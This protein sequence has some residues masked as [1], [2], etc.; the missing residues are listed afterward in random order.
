MAISRISLIIDMPADQSRY[1][2][3]ESCLQSLI[4]AAAPEEVHI[5]STLKD[6][7]CI[8]TDSQVKAFLLYLSYQYFS[9]PGAP[10]PVILHGFYKTK[11]QVIS[12]GTPSAFSKKT[13]EQVFLSIIKKQNTVHYQNPYI[14]ERAV[15]MI[16]EQYDSLSLE[17]LS[18][19]LDV[20]HSYLCRIISKD[21]GYSFLELLHFRR[22]LAV[23]GEFLLP[24]GCSTEALCLNLGY[25]SL[26]HFHR[27]FKQYTELTPAGAKK[28]L[29][30]LNAD[31]I[32]FK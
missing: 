12:S 9:C 15:R 27:V 5:V 10:L 1:S 3:V 21:T 30:E 24:T 13:L 14:T 26:H 17:L 6:S 4:H 20:S 7:E 2:L 32:N 19:R 11:E 16:S 22:I 29:A 28:L 23:A 25:A 18:E 31:I 8:M